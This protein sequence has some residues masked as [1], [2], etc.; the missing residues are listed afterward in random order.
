M[1]TTNFLSEVT[2]CLGQE[3]NRASTEHKL[4]SDVPNSTVWHPED[5]KQHDYCREK[6]KYRKVFDSF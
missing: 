3:L 6:L 4:G 1:G 5:L 2:W